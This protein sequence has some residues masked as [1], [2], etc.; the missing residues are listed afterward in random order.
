MER[1][2]EL[3]YHLSRLNQYGRMPQVLV[4]LDSPMAVDVTR[5]FQQHKDC[6]DQDLGYGDRRE[7]DFDFPVCNSAARTGIQDDQ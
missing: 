5:V 2:Q 6:F 1:S 4:F 3:I 7:V